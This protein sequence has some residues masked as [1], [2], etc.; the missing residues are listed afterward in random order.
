MLRI[1]R[2]IF[3]Y[4]P[5]DIGFSIRIPCFPL[6]L[7]SL[8]NLSHIKQHLHYSHDAAALQFHVELR[9]LLRFIRRKKAL[10]GHSTMRPY[11]RLQRM[12][13]SS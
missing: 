6:E 7:N 9:N 8:G 3:S 4:Q 5:V 13:Q 1:T 11:L 10:S 2:E 12:C